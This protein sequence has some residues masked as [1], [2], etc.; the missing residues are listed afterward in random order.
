MSYTPLRLLHHT[1]TFPVAATSLGSRKQQFMPLSFPE[2]L[3]YHM[4]DR[5]HN[6]QSDP[7]P[8]SVQSLHNPEPPVLV[9]R[10]WPIYTVCSDTVSAANNEL[11]K[12]MV[13][14]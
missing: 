11:R 1:R 3:L 2:A 12:N 6:L 5:A 14:L 9:P 13:I 10:G 4:M 7:A 8:A